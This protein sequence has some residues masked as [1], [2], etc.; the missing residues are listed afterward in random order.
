M[1]F[2]A[3]AVLRLQV[4]PGPDA[5]PAHL[6]PVEVESRTY[7]EA[8][9]VH[10]GDTLAGLL[11]R[12]RVGLTEIDRILREIRAN[13]YF[14][15]RSIVPGQVI[16]FERDEGERL[17]RLTCRVSPEEIY[18]FEMEPASDSLRS[19]A[20]AVD[21][22]V[23]VR[24]L[25]GPIQSTF[26]EAVL[27]AG[28]DSRLA[29]KVADILSGDIDFFTE[30]RRGDQFS[31][32][33][34]ERY[35]DGSFVGYG[36]VLYGWYRGDQATCNAV[37]YRPSGGKGGY[38]DLEGRSLRRAFLKSPLNYRRIS[39]FFSRNRW[40]PIL[41]RYRPHHGVDYAAPIGTPVVAVAD[42]LVEFAGWKG[43]YGRTIKIRH[44][45]THSTIYGHLNGFAAGLRKGS[46]IQQGD[47]VGYVGK[48][49]LTTGPHLHFEVLEQG[50]S[51]NPLA[52]KVVP[53][54]PIP[55]SQLPEFRR[56]AQEMVAADLQMASG[57]ILEPT[58]WQGLLLAYQGG[59][60]STSA[61]TS[62]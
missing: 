41:K 15:P 37:Y 29:I 9:T 34:E 33:V 17:L 5:G 50:R 2:L 47:K 14:S 51:I 31:L 26:E 39:S 1:G 12:N 38:Y 22:E 44:S 59:S 3:L 21:C 56:L 6:P 20:Q 58:T 36:E 49:G 23:R 8:D 61:P 11:L 53:A 54:E 57:A 62:N 28:G 27:S 40:H 42:G 4:R 24:K 19:Y 25:A 43:G 35:V 52:M 13:E 32:L 48:T 16:E 18:V 30:V 7:V 45:S 55:G 60:Y 10:R 46:R